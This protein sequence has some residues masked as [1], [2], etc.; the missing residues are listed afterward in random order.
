MVPHMTRGEILSNDMYYT[1]KRHNF[2]KHNATLGIPGD[3]ANK[4]TFSFSLSHSAVLIGKPIYP[5]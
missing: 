2:I 3:S 1:N 4:G 5:N